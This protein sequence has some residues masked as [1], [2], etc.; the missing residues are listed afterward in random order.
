MDQILFKQICKDLNDNIEIIKIDKDFHMTPKSIDNNINK[1]LVFADNSV[2]S[3]YLSLINDNMYLPAVYRK[4][5]NATNQ[6]DPTNHDVLQPN[7]ILED[8]VRWSELNRKQESYAYRHKQSGLVYGVVSN[9]HKLLQ[10]LDIL[11]N[12]YENIFHGIPH[13]VSFEHNHFRMRINVVLD[14]IAVELVGNNAMKF[15]MSIGNSMFGVGSAF[16]Y[17][18]SYEMWCTNGAMGWRT[19]FNKKYNLD[20]NDIF[21]FRRSHVIAPIKIL[22]DMNTNTIKQL[23]H[24]D[25]Y[26]EQLEQANEINETIFTE[27]EQ[28]DEQLQKDKFKLSKSEAQQA[29]LLMKH[30]HE[31]YGR[32]NGFDTGRAIAEV[33]R[34]TTNMD[35]KIELENIASTIMFSQL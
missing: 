20:S 29:Y 7:Q 1:N 21:E 28:I 17:A 23:S 10:D 16:I 4:L 18:G 34:D 9:K 35:R 22:K 11:E 26:M 14:E 31:Q 5:S 8:L 12:I 19:K 24:A 32:M 3:Q 13:T 30:K 2:R 6:T 15:R 33:A 27:K 25:K